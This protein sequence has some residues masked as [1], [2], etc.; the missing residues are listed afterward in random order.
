MAF[1]DVCVPLPAEQYVGLFFSPL[2]PTTPRE[3]SLFW[4]NVAEVGLDAVTYVVSALEQRAAA[5]RAR[6]K[7]ALDA[8]PAQR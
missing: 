1:V 8:A 7:A 6:V 4:E 5:D 2:G 3:F